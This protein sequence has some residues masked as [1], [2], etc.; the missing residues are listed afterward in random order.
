MNHPI[1]NSELS[2]PD[3]PRW[4]AF[5]LNEIEDVLT[6]AQAAQMQ[7]LYQHDPAIRAVVNDIRQTARQ[8]NSALA[9]EIASGPSMLLGDARRTIIMDE[10]AEVYADS[11]STDAT[12]ARSDVYHILTHPPQAIGWRRYERFAVAAA[13][14]FTA[15]LITMILTL[16]VSREARKN[17]NIAGNNPR[18]ATKSIAAPGIPFN[19]FST[20]RR[21]P[22][23]DPYISVP[24]ASG[25]TPR[26]LFLRDLAMHNSWDT[27]TE[28]SG[29]PVFSGLFAK[30]LSASSTGV[31]SNNMF[32][33]TLENRFVSSLQ[34]PI[35]AFAFHVG[36]GAMASTKAAIEA[37][38]LPPRDWVRI[39]QMLNDF[40][41][42]RDSVARSSEPFAIQ[43]ESHACPWNEK[44]RLVFIGV[45]ARDGKSTDEIIAR[46]IRLQLEFNPQAVNSYRLIGYDHHHLV[47]GDVEISPKAAPT[48][49][50]GQSV[51]A[52][53][54]VIPS[55]PEK[56]KPTEGFA[57]VQPAAVRADKPR[58]EIFSIHLQYADVRGGDHKI[59]MVRTDE[60]FARQDN[61]NN[62]TSA[63]FNLASAIATYGMVLQNSPH[64]GEASLDMALE[65]ALDGAKND[66]TG[67]RA[68]LVELIRQT[69]K[70]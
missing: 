61:H 49:H 62:T 18:P 28:D 7:E 56:S 11:D 38:K 27:M 6:D 23:P 5:A 10:A 2:H 26:E 37:G 50:A 63:D 59:D 12:T 64:K 48:V 44:H 24:M 68:K 35:S 4:T 34:Q 20:T 52:L 47:G 19:P 46:T 40:R 51:R 60:E 58:D 30:V 67:E 3:D 41:Y 70:I 43:Y 55:E 66:P 22:D 15:S 54:E 39:E 13:I 45:V 9:T 33:V 17:Q 1:S 16:M 14:A 29:S 53:Y 57:Y 69:K 36:T 25:H 31:A 8:M 42:S 65:L 32:S 21:S